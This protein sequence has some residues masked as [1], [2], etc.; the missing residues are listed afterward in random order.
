MRDYKI[1]FLDAA[2]I[3]QVEEIAELHKFGELILWEYTPVEK[4]IDR[5][6]DAE[7]LIINKVKL[8]QQVLSQAPK[9]KL[10]CI[11]ATGTDNVDTEY[12]ESR[13]IPVKNAKAYAAESVAQHSFAVLLHLL[14]KLDF[15]QQYIHDGSYSRGKIFTNVSRNIPLLKGKQMGIIGLGN[16]GSAV[17]RI[18]DKG[19]GM[20]VNYHSPSGWKDATSYQHMELSELLQSSDV[21]SIHTSLNK[22]SRQLID[23]KK[24][25]MMKENAVL[26]N[27]GRGAIIKEED[28]AT[29]LNEG[30]L[31]GAC[32]DV[33]EEEPLTLDHPYFSVKNREKLVLTPHIGW[34]ALEARK[35]LM[36]MILD[37]VKAFVDLN[38]GN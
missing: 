7:I 25:R 31:A 18:A 34:A 14:H 1:V 20:K 15:H 23:L 9:L 5:I 19:F 6:R 10:I 37:E 32:I 2:T 33:F 35:N 28:L 26:I 29:A 22:F 4:V 13:G 36:R 17:A 3:G 16:I 30:M 38:S 12:A 8:T 21:L 27:M 24:I 11:T